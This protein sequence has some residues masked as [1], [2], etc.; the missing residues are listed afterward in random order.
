[1]NVFLLWHVRPSEL[2][3]EGDTKLVGV[4]GSEEAVLQATARLRDKPGFSEF[5]HVTG[6]ESE[7]SEE[8]GF[9]ISEYQLDE[10]HWADG[11]GG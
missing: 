5:P 9:H 10:D 3:P 4:Y 8:G 7:M 1:M 11:F 6:P 2:D